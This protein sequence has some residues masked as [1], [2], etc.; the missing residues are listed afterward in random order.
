MS[1]TRATHV[2]CRRPTELVVLYETTQ[3]DEIAALARALE[4]APAA[5]AYCMC[6]GT[7]VFEIDGTNVTLHHGESLRWDGSGGNA[8]LVDPDAVMAWLSARGITFVR[9]EYDAAKVRSDEGAIEAARWRAA[10]PS[11]LLPFFDDMRASGWS[12][13]PEWTAAVEAQH[14]DL[15]ERTRVMLELY[16]SGVGRWSGYPSWEQVPMQ[17]VVELPY[18]VLIAAI[19]DAPSE[20]LCAGA[21][22]LICSWDFRKRRK[23][24][25][26]K[27]SD[28]ARR[29]LL[30]HAQTLPDD[31][32]EKAVDCLRA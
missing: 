7:L 28:A 19:G 11:S 25:V 30:E 1:W 20:R 6:I 26:P 15:V 12:S 16:G 10:M 27:L 13:K 22:R 24:L 2:R 3:R 4:A 18:E 31:Q 14:P 5:G 29:R 8:A 17:L 23:Q 32:L 21:V 9:E